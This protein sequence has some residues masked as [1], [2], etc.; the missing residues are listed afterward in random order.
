MPRYSV[1][2]AAG[3]KTRL[4]Y[5]GR[6]LQIVSTGAANTVDVEVEWGGDQQNTELFGAFNDGDAI[7]GGAFAFL[8]LSLTAAVDCVVDLLVSRQD[9]ALVNGQSVNAT[10][11]N[12]LP[13]PVDLDRGDNPATPVY[14]SGTVLGDTPANTVT[15]A[16]A[17]AAGPVAAALL[18]ADATRLEAVIFNQGPD[19]VALGMAGITWAKRAIVLNAGD[20]WIES[21]AAGKA[22]Y[23]ITDAGLNASVTV[24]ERKS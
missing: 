16:A 15:D 14:V 21:R 10:I 7:K 6:A 12:P 20:V 13:V 1:P 3:K 8:G 23:A 5:P 17:V 9:V 18:A 19:P 11:V 4:P 2:L 22:W 24:Q